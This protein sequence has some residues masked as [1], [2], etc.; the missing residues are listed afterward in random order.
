MEHDVSFGNWVRRRR[1][2]LEMTQAAGNVAETGQVW[3]KHGQ[4]EESE[5]GLAA[6]VQRLLERLERDYPGSDQT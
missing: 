6:P 4:S 2:M 3:Y 5:L 1:T